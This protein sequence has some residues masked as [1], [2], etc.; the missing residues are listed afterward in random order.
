M[1]VL[2]VQPGRPAHVVQDLQFEV[3]FDT[4]ELAF[5]TQ[6]RVRSFAQGAA[7][8]V[9]EEVFDEVGS[10][11]QVL[12]L[13][14]LEI[15]L[16]EMDAD[17]LES[18]WLER[19]RDRLRKEL[20]RL[21]AESAEGAEVTRSGAA[22]HPRRRDAHDE[23]LHTLLHFFRHGAWPWHESAAT[24]P[25]ALA[26]VVWQY[27]ADALLAQLR[28]WPEPA[29]VAR[30]MVRQLPTA[31]CA[32]V[33]AGLHAGA[34]AGDDA[35]GAW[36]AD[37]RHA[38]ER[39]LRA[40]QGEAATMASAGGQA[41]SAR[42]ASGNRQERDGTPAVASPQ[43]A[44]RAARRRLRA[45]LAD[46]APALSEDDL[47]ELLHLWGQL[48]GADG[49]GLRQ[50]L[51][52]MGRLAR[53]RRRMARLWPESLLQQLPSLWP[54]P[55]TGAATTAGVPEVPGGAP[56]LA[57]RVRAGAVAVRRQ[58]WE[59]LL[60]HLWVG[61]ASGHVE[62]RRLLATLDAPAPAPAPAPLRLTTGRAETSAPLPP[63]A[64]APAPIDETGARRRAPHGA[65]ATW[66][67][68][69]RLSAV[70]THAALAHELAGRMPA[71]EAEALASLAFGPLPRVWLR[72]GGVPAPGSAPLCLWA[73]QLLHER[74]GAAITAPVL[75]DHWWR[76]LAV[77]LRR[78]PYELWAAL[79]AVVDD[80]AEAAKCRAWAR[81]LPTRPSS[82]AAVADASVA[83][84][85]LERGE[86]EGAGETLAAARTALL[87]G[88]ASAAR[89]ALQRI[90][91]EPRL[92]DALTLGLGGP[93]WEKLPPLFLPEA[94]AHRVVALQ[95]CLALELHAAV[96]EAELQAF[97]REEALLSL[98]WRPQLGAA[99]L[100]RHLAEQA[101]RRA[102]LPLPVLARRLPVDLRHWLGIDAP[103][104][105]PDFARPARAPI[106]LPAAGKADA[107]AA[108]RAIVALRGAADMHDLAGA[109]R[110]LL[111]ALAERGSP[112]A[113]EAV[114]RE[115]ESARSAQRLADALPPDDLLRV[116]AWLRP[117]DAVALQSLWPALRARAEVSGAAAWPRAARI[118]L[119]ELFEEDRLLSPPALLQRVEGELQRSGE[120]P[121][122]PSTPLAPAAGPAG[123]PWP[124]EPLENTLFVANAG[125]VLI[126][127]F[128]QRLFE[129]LD[130]VVDK[131]FVGVPAAE[132]A[133]A[134][135][136]YAVTAQSQAAEPLLVLNKLLCGL[137]L[138][139][140]VPREA[141][142][143]A[144]ER[145]AVD[146]LLLA[147][148]GHW[149]ALGRTSLAGLRQ[150]FL[151]R[152][153]RLEHRG[154]AWHLEVQPQTF[155]MLIDRLP[156][157]FSTV[158]F[159][160]MREVLHVQWR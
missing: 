42:D 43:A 113:R 126:A 6:E 105:A 137:P 25:V 17:D 102:G 45:L 107:E 30:R 139:A 125:V 93:S 52:T 98:L 3:D 26:Q 22:P 123:E 150:T 60:R 82:G 160:W 38:E 28:N 151:Q 110:S 132:R 37:A 50:G 92:L 65:A 39:L 97:L 13:E 141:Q 11:P 46:D 81:W 47:A 142:L 104:P 112:S 67:R 21:L 20:R 133:V 155:D 74:P 148:I 73:L 152:E 140:P 44:I 87:E 135:I 144:Q 124:I 75:V 108:G 54:E 147:A 55:A 12:R 80:E 35:P 8:R 78:S 5:E 1:S 100:G 71:A 159:P 36:P 34:A 143:A 134:L 91:E 32:Q 68:R 118:V 146:G 145:E 86:G 117:A 48:R 62:A 64:Q 40:L 85:E 83:L 9:L 61:G 59:E 96:S 10:A 119:R 57:L 153:G 103:E 94:G 4:E 127:P 23:A 15:D 16:G 66:T 53:V 2:L 58:R 109:E 156:W 138:Q 128:L 120:A 114:A 56:A 14:Q 69:W 49:D 18:Q 33:H 84:R 157:G 111:L 70:M 88:D 158:R 95:Q 72:E 121:S 27:R 19:L 24:D 77:H 116:V 7:L 101:A 51:E 130:L 149:G 129:R 106:A 79:R 89:A 131:Q 76:A 63:Q 29:A 90:G 41:R 154:E 99:A 31:W 122:T 136:Q 115:L